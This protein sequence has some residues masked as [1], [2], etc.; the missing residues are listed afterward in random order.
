MIRSKLSYLVVL[1]SLAGCGSKSPTTTAEAKAPDPKVEA[2][3]SKLV[4]MLP[5]RWEVPLKSGKSLIV[6]Y[7]A[8]SRG[9]VLVETWAPGTRAE[10]LSTLHRD[11]D[12]VLLTHYCGQGNQPRLALDSVEGNRLR[13]RQIDVTDLDPDES[14]LS[15]LVLTLEPGTRSRNETYASAEKSDSTL[16]VFQRMK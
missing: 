1:A 11:H 5:G 13:F 3:W 12:R 14:A 16:M 9:S 10:T 15:E 7:R 2:A 4:A 8:T 6:E